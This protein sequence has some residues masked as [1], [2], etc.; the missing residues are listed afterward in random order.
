[1]VTNVSP[2]EPDMLTRSEANVPVLLAKEYI[3]HS[4][5]GTLEIIYPVVTLMTSTTA[6]S[7]D[8]KY[9][10]SLIVLCDNC[11]RLYLSFRGCHH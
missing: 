1:M 5:E 4:P 7:L 8:I 11:E 6:V 9:I 3:R 2:D 10:E